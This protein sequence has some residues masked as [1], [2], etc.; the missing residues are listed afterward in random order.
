[1]QTSSLNEAHEA[2]N[3]LEEVLSSIIAQER[4]T[5]A[6]EHELAL[7]QRDAVVA[8]LRREVV[9]K[10]FEFEQKVEDVVFW[11]ETA[12]A[13]A[14]ENVRDGKDGEPGTPGLVGPIGEK[15]DPGTRGE[16]GDWGNKGKQ[17]PTGEPGQPGP[18]GSLGE[19]G[20]P[21]IQG[22]QGIPGEK[23][24]NGSP[25]EQGAVGEKGEKGETGQIGPTGLPGEK[26][27]IGLTGERGEQGL[28]G[29]PGTV[30]KDGAIGERGEK[31]EPGRDGADVVSGFIDREGNGILT[32]TNGQT[33]TLGI[34][35]G[36]DGKDGVDA[37]LNQNKVEAIVANC[38]DKALVAV[39]APEMFASD[40]VASIIGQGIALLSESLPIPEWK[41]TTTVTETKTPIVV[42][43]DNG[44]SARTKTITTRRD[45]GGN[46][47]ADVV[48]N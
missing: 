33:I 48:E 29:I 37:D 2:S 4:R 11:A 32:L 24:N 27:E 23:G 17:G 6:R 31:G 42:N 8:D 43:I 3:A 16:K 21:G 15:G 30:G 41:A 1:M 34:L 13:K 10:Q 46:L 12:V 26:G 20:I 40:D 9:E 22:I 44:P 25:G 45:E 5:W 14:I 38:V 36:K 19:Q 18:S 35:V 47:V 39:P 28:P 7:A